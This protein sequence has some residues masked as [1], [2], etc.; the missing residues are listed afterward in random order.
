MFEELLWLFSQDINGCSLNL[1]EVPL[2]IT[3]EVS[4][5]PNIKI[6]RYLCRIIVCYEK[7]I[8]LW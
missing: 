2:L 8:S 6:S 1:E 7:E 3:H 4:L 5:S